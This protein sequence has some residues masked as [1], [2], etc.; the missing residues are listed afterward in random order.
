M[1]TNIALK[2]ARKAQRRKQAVAAKRQEEVI[3][4]SLA[5]RVRRAA[6]TPIQHCLLTESLLENGLGTLLLAR[7]PSPRQLALSSFLIDP[8]CLGIKDV[9]FRQ[10]GGDEFEEYLTIMGGASPLAPV[11]PSYARKLLRELAAWAQSIGFAPPRDFE[12][13]ERVFGDVDAGTCDVAFEFGKDGK[14]FYMPGPTESP[15]LVRRRLEHLR[16][17][18]GDDGFGYGDPPE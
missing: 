14:P 8:F 11:D 4:A 5:G 7:G 12:I 2:R 10:L 9:F 1:A 17:K 3:E 6:E 13:L 15:S 16:R 18:L